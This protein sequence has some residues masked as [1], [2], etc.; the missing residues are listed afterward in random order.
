LQGC[1]RLGKLLLT[2]NDV[3]L[4]V[5]E[6]RRNLTTGFVGLFL[7][8][9]LIGRGTMNQ[10]IAFRPGPELQAKLQM[11]RD[12]LQQSTSDVMRQIL[13]MVNAEQLRQ[14]M[15]ESSA[16]QAEPVA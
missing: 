9:A 2:R 11:L 8:V 1:K 6:A 15:Q 3:A 12:G 5:T 7:F 16:E 13:R 4:G 10:V 14:A